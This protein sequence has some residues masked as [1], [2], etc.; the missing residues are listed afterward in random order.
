MTLPASA[1]LGDSLSVTDGN[2]LLSTIL[3]ATDI[4]AGSVSYTLPAGTDG[5]LLS[6]DASLTDVAGNTSSSDND[7]AAFD[8]TPPSAPQVLISQD[9]ND[10]ALINIAENNA[11]DPANVAIALF[12]PIDANAGDTLD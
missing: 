1:S 7:I 8:F 9:A 6:V 12:L 11:N 4:S 2:T 3:S 5:L 10:D